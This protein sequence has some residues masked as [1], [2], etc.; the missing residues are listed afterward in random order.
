M[1][2]LSLHILD[3]AENSLAAGANRIEIYIRESDDQLVLEVRDNGSGMDEELLK[4]VSD[5]FFT[6]KTV[7]KVGLGIPLLKQAAEECGGELTIHSEKGKGTIITAKFRRSHIDLKPMGDIGATIMVLIAGN[8]DID[9]VLEYNKEGKI[10]RFNTEE[11][12]ADLEGMPINLPAL[13]GIIKEEINKG[14]RN[15]KGGGK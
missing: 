10:Y 6:T 11:L 3:I 8:P 15:I 1:E 13:L 9:I 5:P 12:R 4:M 7:R 14:I 2:D